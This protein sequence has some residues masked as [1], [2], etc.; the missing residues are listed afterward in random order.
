[1]SEYK[2]NGGFNRNENGNANPQVM[3]PEQTCTCCEETKKGFLDQAKDFASKNKTKLIVA[4]AI[5]GGGMLISW[6]EKKYGL[7][8]KTYNKVFGKK[9]EPQPEAPVEEK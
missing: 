4:A 9:A 6:E 3:K 2:N 8:K 7:I 1:M 5:I